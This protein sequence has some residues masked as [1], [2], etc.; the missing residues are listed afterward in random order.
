MK[1][2]AVALENI[3][4]FKDKTVVRFNNNTILIGPN[5]GGKSTLVN[6]IAFALNYSFT[7]NMQHEGEDR[8][9]PSSNQNHQQRL[10]PNRETPNSIS[11]V[12]LELEITNNDIS[13]FQELR[14]AIANEPKRFSRIYRTDPIAAQ[15]NL[16]FLVPLKIGE[17]IC[18]KI[19][20]ANGVPQGITPIADVENTDPNGDLRPAALSS[21]WKLYSMWKALAQDQL[22]HFPYLLFPTI[23]DVGGMGVNLAQPD[24]VIQQ[25][26]SYSDQVR[27]LGTNRQGSLSHTMLAASALAGRHFD[28]REKSGLDYAN[29]EFVTSTMAKEVESDLQKFGFGF[30]VK[31]VG[32][33]RV[34]QYEI[35]VTQHEKQFPIH[36]ASSGERQVLNFVFALGTLKIE[37]ALVLID[38]PEL[39]LHPRWQNKLLELFLRKA[40]EKNIQL[41]ISTHS[42]TFITPDSFQY[43]ARIYRDAEGTKVRKPTTKVAIE[44]GIV[45]MINAHNNSRIFFAD[46]VVLVEGLSDELFWHKL[47]SELQGEKELFPVIEIVAVNGKNNFTKYR[48]LLDDLAIGNYVIADL[49]YIANLSGASAKKFFVAN[50]TKINTQVS[51]KSSEDGKTLIQKIRAFFSIMPRKEK[52]LKDCLDYLESRHLRLKPNLNAVETAELKALIDIHRANKIAVCREGE[53]ENYIPSSDS[54]K[55][56]GVL[57]FTLDA[58]LWKNWFDTASAGGDG[59]ELVEIAKAAIAAAGR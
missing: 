43:V 53:L 5:G 46:S 50:D 31:T 16:E 7:Q 26:S 58:Q 4:S 55:I 19:V 48:E 28:L 10:S 22:P 47:I 34:N 37:N 40:K 44:K 49:D 29:T 1:L 52:D 13:A 6:A 41:I 39:N 2:L 27:A 11:Y 36:E 8:I 20:F 30:L 23:R 57:A 24:A 35:L 14:D 25:V 59:A 45:Q 33:T 42:P 9:G 21:F 54:D 56:G 18:F 32:L 17:K 38:E 15:R 51:S 12:A 3:S